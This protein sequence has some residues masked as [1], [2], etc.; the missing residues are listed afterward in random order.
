MLFLTLLALF[1]IEMEHLLI[2]TAMP[3]E[4]LCESYVHSLGV[5]VK[6]PYFDDG[7]IILITIELLIISISFPFCNKKNELI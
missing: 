6:S 4:L 5:C 3:G 7:V 2:V 1:F